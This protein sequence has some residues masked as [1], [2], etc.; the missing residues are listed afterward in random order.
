MSKRKPFVIRDFNPTNEGG[1]NCT[2]VI[3]NRATFQEAVTENFIDAKFMVIDSALNEVSDASVPEIDVINIKV[4]TPIQSKDDLRSYRTGV[5]EVIKRWSEKCRIRGRRGWRANAIKTPMFKRDPKSG[6][7]DLKF[8]VILGRKITY[9]DRQ[10]KEI[11]H[12]FTSSYDDLKSLKDKLG[13]TFAAPIE[14]KY[15]HSRFGK[16]VI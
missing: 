4:E 5:R 15:K 1:F 8:E 14:L 6:L 9:N 12:D 13:D 11:L 3:D 2:G 10:S 16:G 7:Y